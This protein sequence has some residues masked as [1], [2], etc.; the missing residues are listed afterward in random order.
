MNGLFPLIVLLLLLF[1]PPEA[2]LAQ[3][4]PH[5]FDSPKSGG[6]PLFSDQVVARGKGFQIKQSQVD[7]LFIA[8]R[9]HRAAIGQEV[10]PSLRPDIEADIL[11]RLIATQLFLQKATEQDKVQARE[12][13]NAF[14]AEQKKLALSEESFRRQ[15]LAVGMTPEEF[16]AQIHEQAVVK[17]VI[18]RE[19]R[20]RK[21]LSDEE[22]KKFYEENPGLF[23]EP[24]TVR[25]SH[26][27]ISTRDSIT[28]QPLTPELRLEK[29]RVAERAL[30]RARA[31]E[32]FAKLVRELSE[33]QATKNSGGE[34][35]FARAR[36]NP[37]QA[38]V[39]EFEAAAFSMAPN[40]ISDLVETAFG[41]HII[42]T[43]AKTPAKTIEFAL[44]E[45][46][47]R[48]NLLR[49]E[50]EKDLPDFIAK[51]REEAGVEIISPAGK[52]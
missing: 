51:L 19:I 1:G 29:K 32:D 8:F 14:I 44:V 45:E 36:D 37:R 26:I 4:K 18:D 5:L 47:I 24:E 9:S 11:D 40:Q 20:A 41:F 10:A 17:A 2:V 22:I 52:R 28:G 38:M 50:V 25:A 13:G 30:A 27:L 42:K 6:R 46:R 3:N 15:L 34:Y 49:D 12:I 23:I 21:K 16:S 33:D 31:G 7:E 39:P 43:L 35:N 48:E